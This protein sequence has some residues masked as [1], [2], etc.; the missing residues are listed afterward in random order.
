MGDKIS[1]TEARKLG[2][3]SSSSVSKLRNIKTEY[4][5][6]KYD[7]KKEAKRAYELDTLLSLK[8]IKSYEPQFIIRIEHNGVK[9]CKYICDFRI[10]NL[11]G[12]VTYEDV[13]GYKKGN[14][15]SMFR[16]KKKLVL[17]F[18]N[19]NIIEI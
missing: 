19:I 8:L 17:A 2:W 12:S 10:V 16:L 13:K 18:H 6:R 1:V 15:Y 11:D 14:A 7:S 9:I 4:N 5:G 3:G